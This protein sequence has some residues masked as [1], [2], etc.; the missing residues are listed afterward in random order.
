M[1]TFGQEVAGA[2]KAKGWTQNQLARKAQLTDQQIS[3]IEND[4][5]ASTVALLGRVARAL[6]GKVLIDDGQPHLVMWPY[7]AMPPGQATADAG[8][9]SEGGSV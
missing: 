3:H 5:Y 1:P 9:E 7:P 6:G 8:A 2:R 4:K